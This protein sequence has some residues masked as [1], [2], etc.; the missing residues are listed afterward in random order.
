[1]I[2]AWSDLDVM[3]KNVTMCGVGPLIIS[4]RERDGRFSA[5][6]NSWTSW[7]GDDEAL[8]QESAKRLGLLRAQQVLEGA[9]QQVG[10][11]IEEIDAIQPQE[12]SRSNHGTSSQAVNP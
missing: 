11:L 2:N 4:V 7:F 1:M 9:L 8:E 5:S 6:V 3:P 10:R 12:V